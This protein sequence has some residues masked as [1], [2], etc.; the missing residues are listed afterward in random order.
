MSCWALN[1]KSFSLLFIVF[2]SSF[3]A[4]DSAELL[5]LQYRRGA[6]L[7]QL[8]GHAL[9]GLLEPLAATHCTGESRSHYQTL[10]TGQGASRTTA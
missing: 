4:T 5:C 8:I 2:T 1:L 3:L 7:D 9:I 10:N 6:I